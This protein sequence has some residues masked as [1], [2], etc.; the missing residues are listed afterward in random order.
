M[1]D[2][3]Y[4]QKRVLNRSKGPAVWALRAQTDKHEYSRTM[5][6]VLE[7]TPNLHIRE[8]MAVG[9]EV[10]SND[11][12]TGVKTFF[13]ITFRA[14]AV[15][16][17]TGT[18]MNGTIWVGRQSMSA[19]RSG[20]QA[21]VGLT[22]ALVELGFEAGRLKTGTP[23]RVDSRTVDF[24]VLEA[25]PGETEPRWFSFDPSAHVDR[26]QLSCYLTHTTAET[27]R[28]IRENLGETPIYGGWVD[29]KGPRY[30]PSI[31]DKIVRFADKGSHQVG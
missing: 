27:H 5:R 17:T 23:A 31:E 26:P 7:T 15:V 14:A 10:N 13:G 29:S 11:E 4:L 8:G 18:F 22:E 19:G 12:I 16:L 9:V 21:S 24:S 28:L 30:C 6:G 2:R 20:E 3:C 1:A 25:Q